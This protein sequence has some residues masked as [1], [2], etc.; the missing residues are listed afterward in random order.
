MTGIETCRAHREALG[1]GM[2]DEFGREWGSNKNCQLHV[3]LTYVDLQ[4]KDHFRFWNYSN[5]WNKK[6]L[7]DLSLCDAW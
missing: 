4:S 3:E 1:A 5:S 6:H 7:Q 2:G